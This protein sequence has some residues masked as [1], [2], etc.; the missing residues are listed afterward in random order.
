MN[1]LTRTAAGLGT[2]LALAV[3]TALVTAAPA[4][5]DVERRGACGAGSYEF[6]VDREDGGLEVSVDVDRVAPGSR[7][8][9]TM[10]HDGNR[11]YRNV[12]RADG[13][14]DLD[15]ERQRPDTSGRDTFRFR[16]KRVG[17]AIA[18]SDRIRVR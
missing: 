18:C 3:P 15:V 5:A 16:A 10:R 9:V 12:L 8:R 7:W 13:E 6:S 17:H 2:A 11:F 4:S 14:G 1:T